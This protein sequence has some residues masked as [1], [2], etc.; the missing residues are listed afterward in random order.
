[1]RWENEQKLNV[2]PNIAQ[3]AYYLTNTQQTREG[4]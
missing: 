3:S 4:K 1:M 2:Q